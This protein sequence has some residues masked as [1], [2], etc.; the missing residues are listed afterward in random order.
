M[1]H[2]V[3]FFFVSI[4]S[5]GGHVFEYCGDNVNGCTYNALPEYGGAPEEVN[6]IIA[7]APARVFYTSSDQSGK[8]KIGDYFSVDQANGSV[9]LSADKFDLS[10]I[11]KLGPFYRK[12]VKQ[13][14]AMEEISPSQDLVS[15]TGLPDGTTVPTQLAVKTYVDTRAVPTN[16]TDSDIGYVLR[17][18]EDGRGYGWKQI[19]MEAL[20]RVNATIRTDVITGL[21]ADGDARV[22]GNVTCDT[23]IASQGA[24]I[25]TGTR[26]MSFNITSDS[27]V[28]LTVTNDATGSSKSTTLTLA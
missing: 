9:A 26:T 16:Y 1:G 10:R 21:I 22:F 13:G 7:I 19:T 28:V 15:S 3:E 17:I 20:G 25:S 4:V 12:N 11:A 8:Q 24:R 6:Q 27:T 18:N 14:V 5:T 2:E 23:L